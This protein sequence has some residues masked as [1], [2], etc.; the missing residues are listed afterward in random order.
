M[1]TEEELRTIKQLE[2][3]QKRTKWTDAAEK[4]YYYYLIRFQL[5]PV[6]VSSIILFVLLP[7]LRVSMP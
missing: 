5:P 2:G 7:L 6:G 1:K 4:S 3:V